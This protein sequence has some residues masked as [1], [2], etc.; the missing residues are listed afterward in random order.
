MAETQ[1]V[2]PNEKAVPDWTV[3]AEPMAYP[4]KKAV[5]QGLM[6]CYTDEACEDVRYSG[7]SMLMENRK[8]QISFVILAYPD[9]ETAKSAFAPVWKAWSGR[10]P[11]G[12]SLDL[13]DIGEQSDAVSGADAS[14]VPGSKGVLSQARV[15]SVILLTHGAAAPKVEMEDSLIAE[16]ATMF[17]ERARQ[18]E[19]G[20]TPSAAMAGT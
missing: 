8:P 4:L 20:E 6:S 9:T 10:V 19:K 16:F 5:S 18:A 1:A 3:A 7:R 15:G 17:A 11:D 14:L 2:L 13:G 12:K